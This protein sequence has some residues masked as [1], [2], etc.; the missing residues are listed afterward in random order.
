M[1]ENSVIVKHENEQPHI[2]HQPDYG[3][4]LISCTYLYNDISMPQQL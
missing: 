1:G 3:N 4:K 2:N